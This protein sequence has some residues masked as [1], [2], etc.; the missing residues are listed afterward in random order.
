MVALLNKIHNYTD[1]INGLLLILY[2]SLVF[3]A[4]S[5]SVNDTDIGIIRGVVL[6][7]V[8][9]VILCP[10]VLKALKKYDFN[11]LLST[12]EPNNSIKLR[13]LFFAVPFAV[14]LI[15]YIAMYPGAFSAD[16]VYQMQQ[17][18]SN[19]YNDWQPAIQTLL[20]I[21]LPLV[22]TGG[23]YGSIV[24]FQIIAFSFAIFYA[25]NSVYRFT[26][27]KTAVI[28]ML[29][30]CLNPFTGN[31][32]M[33][34]WKDVSF[35]I[36]T[37]FLVT[38]AFN[39]CF[40]EGKWIK[41]VPNTAALI[42]ITGIATLVRHNAVLFTVPYIIA[43]LLMISK[44]RA[45]IVLMGIIVVVAGIKV[46]LYSALNVEPASKGI[47]EVVGLPL[48]VIGGVTVDDSDS[49]D[50]ETREFVYEIAPKDVWE[51]H[52]SDGYNSIKLRGL[53]NNDVVNQ[54]GAKKVIRMMLN[55]FKRSPA[56]ATKSLLNVL[57]V[58]YSVS[59]G[60]IY[61]VEPWTYPNDLN[62]N[63]KSYTFFNALNHGYIVVCG[64]LLPHLFFY[65]GS[66]L[67]LLILA[68]LSKCRLDSS[69]DLKRILLCASVFAYNYG[70]ALLLTGPEDSA[71]FFYYT[72]LV[73]PLLLIIML[74]K[75]ETKESKEL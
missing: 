16:S 73:T 68:I 33:Y 31:I 6:S 9:S 22:L 67:L 13:V 5:V 20:A 23:W 64:I 7:V 37:L 74:K 52:Y 30:M 58:V 72:F 41:S 1:G 57:K 47:V 49:L 66:M 38:F 63:T 71:R 56:V 29:F 51:E 46:P 36:C 27:V 28:V 45:I 75:K 34:P 53:A 12:K 17:A 43:V 62:I 48:C 35:A 19:N 44:K 4:Y 50:G 26:N 10:I 21:K 40:T 2:S 59:D 3:S 18:L 15:H 8:S 69:A 42:V 32:A 25:I 65:V 70:T 55:C 61:A 11:K 60:Y 14:F 39:I 54:Y 24:L